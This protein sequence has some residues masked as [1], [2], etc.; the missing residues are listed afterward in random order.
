MIYAVFN[1]I[2]PK[3]SK[4]EFWKRL[5]ESFLALFDGVWPQGSSKQG[6][7]LAGGYR[8]CLWMLKGDLKYWNED[9]DL[10]SHSADVPC[11]LCPANSSTL[12]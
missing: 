5:L 10:P 2:F 8:A 6:E 12:P 9:L 4:R 1:S 3:L 11:A 7:P